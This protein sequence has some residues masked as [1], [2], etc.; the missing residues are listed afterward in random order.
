MDTNQNP[1]LAQK[2]R[3]KSVGGNRAG[4]FVNGRVWR[5]PARYWHGNDLSTRSLLNGK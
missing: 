5:A 2:D 1:V 3:Q 4:E